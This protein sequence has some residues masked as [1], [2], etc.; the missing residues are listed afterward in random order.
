MEYSL[1]I[2]FHIKSF[3]DSKQ[4]PFSCVFRWGNSQKS[5]GPIS[6]EYGA[7]WTTGM[8]YLAKKVWI[9]CKEWAGALSW[10]SCYV[11]AWPNHWSKW[12]VP[13]QCLSPPPPQVLRRWHNGPAWPKSALGP[14]TRH[15][16]LLRA[17][18]NERHSP[19]TRRHLW[20]DCTTP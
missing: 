14:W 17:Y 11:P 20:I 13:N 9:S 12:N 1:A 3:R 6:G 7:C 4:V 15:F 5:Q 8:L 2:V 10:C 19:P 16:G 18:W